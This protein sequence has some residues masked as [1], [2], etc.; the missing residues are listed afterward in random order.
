MY[1][2]GGLLVR[3]VSCGMQWHRKMNFSRGGGGTD[4]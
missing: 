2:M 1:V 3:M 4:Y